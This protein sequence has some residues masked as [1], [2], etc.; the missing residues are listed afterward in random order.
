MNT[1]ISVIEKNKEL[2]LILKRKNKY[3]YVDIKTINDSKIIYEFFDSIRDDIISYEINKNTLDICLDNDVKL[4]IP[5]NVDKSNLATFGPINDGLRS[6]NKVKQKKKKR[7]VVGIKLTVFA[8]LLIT[9]TCLFKTN[10]DVSK[11]F[12]DKV[13][14]IHWFWEK[15][16]EITPEAVIN[17]EINDI[18]EEKITFN[19]EIVAANPY[20]NVLSKSVSQDEDVE[21][22]SYQEY[23]PD[24]GMSCYD[25]KYTSVF[26]NYGDTVKKYSDISGIDREILNCVLA[27]ERGTHSTDPDEGGAIGIAQIQ[28]NQHL[29]EKLTLYNVMTGEKETF[30]VTMELLQSVDGNIKVCVALL[31]S[32]WI[33]FE[34]N[35]F[36]ML[37]AYNYGEG[38]VNTIVR[39]DGNTLEDINENYSVLSF[40]NEIY[41]YRNGTYGDKYYLNNVFMRYPS[42]KLTVCYGDHPF[43]SSKKKVINIDNPY[44]ISDD[45]LFMDQSDI[46]YNKKVMQIIKRMA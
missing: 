34:G 9:G 45:L 19:P 42:D 1:Y 3:G 16:P 22:I 40:L 46:E 14:A 25:K 15:E 18:T 39:R 29:G 36:L 5:T 4:R 38:A 8:F 30:T 11:S 43:D 32:A 6:F 21:K 20:I 10:K 28:V 35:I 24:F 41:N 13:K 26:E 12:S 31:Q 44:N 23:L 17:E 7:I 37:Q 27:Q 2:Q 33:E